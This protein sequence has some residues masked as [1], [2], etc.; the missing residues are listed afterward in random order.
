LNRGAGDAGRWALASS[1]GLLSGC[2]A[3]ASIVSFHKGDLIMSRVGSVA[4]T[5]LV[6]YGVIIFLVYLIVFFKDRP[7]MPG[8]TFAILILLGLF[9]L[10]V[11][12]IVGK[13][14]KAKIQRV[15]LRM[16]G[17]DPSKWS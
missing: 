11:W 4:L 17:E 5:W 10:W 7:D 2:A 13:Q 12:W 15:F 3:L 16:F 14:G 1:S 6:V 9:W 8:S